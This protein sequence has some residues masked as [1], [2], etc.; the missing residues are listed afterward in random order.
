[1]KIDTLPNLNSRPQMPDF[2]ARIR[3]ARIACG[4][5]QTELGKEVGWSSPTAL[6]YIEKNKRGI[7]VKDLL[8]IAHTTNKPITFFYELE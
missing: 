7:T 5:S 6:S 2:G 8:Q 3:E 4:L 1:M